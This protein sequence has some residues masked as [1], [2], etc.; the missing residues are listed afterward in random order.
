MGMD[1]LSWIDKNFKAGGLEVKWES[2]S[3][4]TIA[5]RRK[6]G[7]GAKI[8]QD[9]GRLKSSFVFGKENNIFTVSGNTVTVGSADK[10]VNWHQKGTRSYDIYPKTKKYLSFIYNGKKV[11]RKKVHHPGLAERPMLPSKHMASGIAKKSLEAYVD[12]VVA[13]VRGM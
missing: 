6:K 8:L 1:M 9:M 12:K 3:P 4:N 11:Y 2:L 7:K 5:A 13:S 10:K